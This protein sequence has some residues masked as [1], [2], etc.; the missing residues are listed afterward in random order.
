MGWWDLLE[1]QMTY[2]EDEEW[3]RL[4]GLDL[5]QSVVSEFG[6]RMSL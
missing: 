5:M 2:R 1:R 6:T 3:R 4:L